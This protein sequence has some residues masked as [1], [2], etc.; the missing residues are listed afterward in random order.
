[1]KLLIIL[2]MQPACTNVDLF[3]MSP[4]KSVQ[5][6]T[7]VAKLRCNLI[8]MFSEDAILAGHDV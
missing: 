3:P 4:S 5:R 2:Q 7:I 8:M 6:V 1:M